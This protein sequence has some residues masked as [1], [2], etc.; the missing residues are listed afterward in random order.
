MIS[1]LSKTFII[2]GNTNDQLKQNFNNALHLEEN[3]EYQLALVS[4]DMFYSVHNITDKNNKFI[5][6]T[7]GGKNFKV[8]NLVKG[9]Y[10]LDKL[11]DEIIETLNFT[12]APFTFKTKKSN[13]SIEIEI[14]DKNFQIDFNNK[15]SFGKLLGFNHILNKGNGIYLSSSINLYPL[16]QIYI[17]CNLIDSTYYNNELKQII[18]NFYPNC[19]PGDKIIEKPNNLIYHSVIKKSIHNIEIKLVDQH[20]NE[21]DFNKETVNICLHLRSI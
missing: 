1:N 9:F 7:D 5:Y 18:Y 13:V 21:I 16:E 20:F 19:L 12:N 8:I 6:S 17:E 11:Y 10:T 15:E 2:S 14:K 4:F 3:K